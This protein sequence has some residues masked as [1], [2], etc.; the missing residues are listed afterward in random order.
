MTVSTDKAPPYSAPASSLP[1]VA[2]LLPGLLIAGLVFY[3]WKASLVAIEKVW[4]SGIL[5]VRTD[6]VTLGQVGRF[7]VVVSMLNYFSVIWPA[8]VFG[9]LISAAVRAFVPREWL[10]RFFKE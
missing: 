8:L 9:I 4:S 2:V 5:S 3:K 10:V 1:P 7:T 6:V